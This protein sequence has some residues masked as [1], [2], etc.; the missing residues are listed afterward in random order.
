MVKPKCFLLDLT[1]PTF[2]SFNL[3]IRAA[4]SWSQ[5]SVLLQERNVCL[6]NTG[7]FFP[8][9]KDEVVY[10]KLSR[11]KQAVFLAVWITLQRK[12]KHHVRVYPMFIWHISARVTFYHS[13][14]W[15]M[16]KLPWILNNLITGMTRLQYR[17]SLKLFEIVPYSPPLLH[18][19]VSFPF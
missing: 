3:I 18:P 8:S 5:M 11:V 9:I 7:T 15:P 10:F 12:A 16:T 13:S 2:W 14:K 6:R 1:R 17:G 4:C 19:S